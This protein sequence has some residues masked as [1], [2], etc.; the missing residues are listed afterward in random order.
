MRCEKKVIV[1][2]HF[3][4]FF[5][6]SSQHSKDPNVQELGKGWF[7]FFF[8]PFPAGVSQLLHSLD[9]LPWQSKIINKYGKA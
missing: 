3:F 1:F 8:L 9:F 7:F 2:L 5:F 4:F 6:F